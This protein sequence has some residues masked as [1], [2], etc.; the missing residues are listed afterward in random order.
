MSHGVKKKPV[1]SA[2]SI[3][4]KT[5]IKSSANTKSFLA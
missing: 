5:T 1:S 3:A 4:G 2:P